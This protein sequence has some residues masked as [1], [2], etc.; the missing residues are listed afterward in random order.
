MRAKEILE[1][2]GLVIQ[3]TSYTCGPVSLLNILRL[4]GDPSYSEE[5]LSQLCKSEPGVGTTQKDLISTA[6]HVGLD[7]IEE[8]DNG[9]LKDLESHLDNGAYVIVNHFHVH[10]GDGHYG[11]ITDY[12]DRALYFVDCSYGYLRLEKKDFLKSWHGT[13]RTGWYAAVS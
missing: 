4:K 1:T 8:K 5:E 6:Q 10:S 11:I 13:V 9:T 2:H 3:E 12:D 7:V